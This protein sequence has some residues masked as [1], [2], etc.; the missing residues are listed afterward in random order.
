MNL[1]KEFASGGGSNSIKQR[2]DQVTK[3]VLAVEKSKP[4]FIDVEGKK[5]EILGGEGLEIP[6]PLTNEPQAL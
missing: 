1:S 2:M 4:V 5:L 6:S 3:T